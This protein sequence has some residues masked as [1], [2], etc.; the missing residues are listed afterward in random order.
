MNADPGSLRA[1]SGTAASASPLPSS[2]SKSGA[3]GPGWAQLAA[4]KLIHLTEQGLHAGRRRL[5]LRRLA[6][7]GG[8]SSVLFVC[9]GNIYRSPFAAAAFLA[10]LPEP[11]RKTI[12]C[13]SAGLTGP[14]RAA[15]ADAVR[16]AESRGVDLRAHRSRLLTGHLVGNAELIV[17]MDASL[18]GLVC[19][20]FGRRRRDVVLLGDLDPNPIETRGIADPW[21]RPPEVL[22]GSYTRLARC[23]RELANALMG[24]RG[25]Y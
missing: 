2:R 22:E 9:V 20:R 12:R 15:P 16:A 24:L 3:T 11:F 18:R 7:R 5:L 17:V 10:A 14:D 25:G 21:D 13:Q 19:R 4:A 6:R 1:N 8:A 23:S